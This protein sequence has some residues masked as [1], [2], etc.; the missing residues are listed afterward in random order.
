MISQISG[1]VGGGM[2]VWP[3]IGILALALLI[4]SIRNLG[5]LFRK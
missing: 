4:V 3:V 5:R 2:W 1:S